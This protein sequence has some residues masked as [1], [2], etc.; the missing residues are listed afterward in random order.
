MTGYFMPH[1][2]DTYHDE[3]ALEIQQELASRKHE[4]RLEQ[5]A[6]SLRSQQQDEDDQSND[7]A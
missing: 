7:Q 4:D 6:E 5:Q 2:P 1:Q 3:S